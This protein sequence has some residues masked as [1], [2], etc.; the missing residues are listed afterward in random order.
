[1]NEVP[2][3]W[4]PALG[5]LQDAWVGVRAE[6]ASTQTARQTRQVLDWSAKLSA[7]RAVQDDLLARGLWGATGP[8]DLLTVAGFGR[9][10]TAH[11]AV[12]AWLLGPA[13]EHGLASRFLDAFLGILGQPPLPA[14]DRGLVRVSTEETRGAR[15][16]DIVVRWPRGAMLVEAKVDAEESPSQCDDLFTLF[17]DEPDV[18]F[19]FLTPTGRR[20]VT[21][22]GPAAEAF[23][24]VSFPQVRECLVAAMAGPD[25]PGSDA[26]RTYLR[27]L[28]THFS[29]SPTVQIDARL[30]FY[31]ENKRILDEWAALAWEARGA[32][33]RF[34]RTLV[35]PVRELQSTL[36]TDVHLYTDLEGSYPKLVLARASWGG[37]V[38]TPRVGVGLEWSKNGAAF[39]KACTGVWVCRSPMD[40]TAALYS[41]VCKELD[42]EGLPKESRNQWWAQYSYEPTP[43]GEW[44]NDLPALGEQLV[45]RLRTRWDATA[46]CIDD[47]LPEVS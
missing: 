40:T 46:E 4:L 8:A 12:L 37:G 30:R 6:V 33:D 9:H 15:R 5:T 11:T 44:W 24:S 39:D 21:A 45:A 1:M 3:H 28:D 10:E 38:G 17:G 36:G 41:A 14:E 29:R 35:E 16:A 20:P 31:F 23:R 47:A 13:R 27:T 19:V 22:T 42:V 43:D 7:L 26:V 2:A 25:A 32:A 34:F 18:S